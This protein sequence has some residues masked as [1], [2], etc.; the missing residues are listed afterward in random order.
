MCYPCRLIKINESMIGHSMHIY[1]ALLACSRYSLAHDKD[2]IRY[3][4][5]VEYNGMRQTRDNPLHQ[6]PLLC[7]GINDKQTKNSLRDKLC[8]ERPYG[9]VCETCEECRR[10]TIIPQ[11]L[12]SHYRVIGRSERK[13]KAG[14]LRPSHLDRLD[15]ISWPFTSATGGLRPGP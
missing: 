9:T 5:W 1:C 13:N 10:L 11:S 4:E 14:I 3:Y 7:E 12:L 2:W 6:N 8:M 15:T